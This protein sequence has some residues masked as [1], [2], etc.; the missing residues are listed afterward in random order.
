MK[1][2]YQLIWDDYCYHIVAP[3]RG[4]ARVAFMEYMD[5]EVEFISSIS[6]C[7]LEKNVDMPDGVD[8]QF[9]WARKNHK[10]IYFFEFTDYFSDIA[11]QDCGHLLW[12]D[13]AGLSFCPECSPEGQVA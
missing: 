6:I 5:F 2:L 4:K 7:I 10:H 1:I 12:E 13:N 8:E 3:S 9:T 11:C